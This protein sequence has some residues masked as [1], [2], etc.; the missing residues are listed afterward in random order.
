MRK[1][2]RYFDVG[3]IGRTLDD[4]ADRVLSLRR[5]LLTDYANDGGQD[6]GG[7]N[8]ARRA[9]EVAI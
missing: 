9:L 2:R 5:L 7:A 8:R 3:C 4:D 6:V 1:P